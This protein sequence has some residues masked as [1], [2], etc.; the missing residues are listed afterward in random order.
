MN[1]IDRVFVSD[2]DLPSN[3]AF[4]RGRSSPS[5]KTPAQHYAG[6]HRTSRWHERGVGTRKTQPG[7]ISPGSIGLV[8]VNWMV[9]VCVGLI[10]I[11]NR[12]VIPYLLGMGVT[13]EPSIVLRAHCV[14]AAIKI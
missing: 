6:S 13:V 2:D 5:H 4:A 11:R 9:V 3:S 10:F 1:M 14:R 7:Q 8:A 12:R